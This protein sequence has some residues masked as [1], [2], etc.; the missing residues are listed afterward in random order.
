[1][2]AIIYKH[3][4]MIFLFLFLISVNFIIFNLFIG[5]KIQNFND[6]HLLSVFTLLKL[7]KVKLI[8]ILLN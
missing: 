2:I 7:S 6:I 3:F 1:M 5:I 8:I 4:G